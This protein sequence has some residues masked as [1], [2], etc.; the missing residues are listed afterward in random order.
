MQWNASLYDN[1]H[2]FVSKY[3][4]DMVDMLRPGPDENILDLGC[5]TGDLA[6]QLSE[7]GCT[8]TGMDA[9]A[10]MI[11]EAARK[12]PSIRF[13][14]ADARDFSL[15]E[16]FDG[17][18]SNAALHWIK[19]EDQ[20]AVLSRVHA[21]LKP[22]GRFV[23]E[24]G[25][26]GNVA[27]LIGAIRQVLMENGHGKHPETGIWYFPSPEAY[28]ALLQQ[29]GF[30]VE[31]MTC[32]ERP[33]ELRDTENGISEWLEMFGASFFQGIPADEKRLLV[34]QIQDRLYDD[35]YRGGHWM[36]DY[37][38]LRFEALRAA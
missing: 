16:T 2:D 6:R 10:E 11:R 13:V 7:T 1:R 12:Y 20:D 17:V 23:A 31:W 30:K 9:S 34:E 33:T 21:H 29:H 32:Y 36:A 4:A 18:F 28:T 15:Q 35:L 24:L 27:K 25:A 38:R 22:Q 14:C 26:R 3:G 8:V 37:R 5:G 19:E